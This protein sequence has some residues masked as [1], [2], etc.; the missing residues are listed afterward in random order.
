M[1]LK[2][3][4]IMRGKRA[5]L[6]VDSNQSKKGMEKGLEKGYTVRSIK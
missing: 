1:K 6:L 3:Y 5:I 2:R 4:V